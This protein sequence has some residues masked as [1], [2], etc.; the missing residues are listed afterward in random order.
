MTHLDGTTHSHFIGDAIVMS[1]DKREF[2]G[3]T[4]VKEV[5]P[6][7][8]RIAF[9]GRSNDF[10]QQ[11]AKDIERYP[12]MAA[13]IERKTNMMIGGGVRYGTVRVDQGVEIM[14]PL[15]IPEIDDW[16]E[17]SQFA[18]ALEEG[19]GDYETY[20]NCFFELVKNKR[21]DKVAGVVCQDALDV[22]LALQDNRG[23]IRK[24]Y[25]A[26]WSGGSNDTDAI[27]FP[28][29]DSYWSKVEQVRSM[30]Q[31]RMILPVRE[32]RRGRRY[33]GITPWDGLRSNG[34]LDIAVRIPLLKK[35]LMNNISNLRFHVEVDERLYQILYTK[36]NEFS[37]KEKIDKRREFGEKLDGWLKKEGIGGVF[38][39]PKVPDKQG[40]NVSSYVTINE[41]RFVLPE[42]AYI[43]DSQ[44]VD[45]IVCRDMGLKPS[46]HGISPSKSGSSPGSG[47]EDRV[48]RLNHILDNRRH[49]D[50]VMRVLDLVSRVNGWQDRYGANG[51]LRFW[52]QNYYAATLDR[53]NQ[54]GGN[55]TD[56][57]R[58]SNG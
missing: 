13:V 15:S 31:S 58:S 30:K 36:W 45:F 21:G 42:G 12:L 49:I 22:R 9:W 33:Y 4:P 23:E 2:T 57:E 44:E 55:K 24:A 3:G 35:V 17:E 5:M 37:D 56:E 8:D 19:Y 20:A 41:K 50:R 48:A 53:T 38:L 52:T 43:E 6:D 46:L 7:G 26:D 47:S 34:M 25:L 10:P 27:T 40:S 11:V 16:M 29:V 1:V 18:L 32:L 54:V 28:V 39:T 14:E 51:P